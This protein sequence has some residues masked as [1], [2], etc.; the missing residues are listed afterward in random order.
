[1]EERGHR[2]ALVPPFYSLVAELAKSRAN[3]IAAG[4]ERSDRG[5]DRG[6]VA[7]SGLEAVIVVDVAADLVDGARQSLGGIGRG[8]DDLHLGAVQR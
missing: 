6:R 1:M 5:I 3:L 2:N 8:D 4:V 7:E